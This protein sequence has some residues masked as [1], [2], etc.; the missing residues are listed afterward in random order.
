MLVVISAYLLT[1]NRPR[2]PS[3]RRHQRSRT[4]GQDRQASLIS[5][6]TSLS[7]ANGFTGT[8]T[9]QIAK[10]AGVSEA[11]LFKHFPTKHALYTAILTEKAQYSEL[12]EAVEEASE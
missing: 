10:A 4:S 1:M 3:R 12:R 7:A 11:L 8:T 2:I 5:A 6:A 9:K